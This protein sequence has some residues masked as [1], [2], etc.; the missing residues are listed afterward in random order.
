MS[1]PRVVPLTTKLLYL[2]GDGNEHAKDALVRA[3]IDDF[4]RSASELTEKTKAGRSKFGNLGDWA[5]ADPV[6]AKLIQRPNPQMLRLTELG[7]ELV[8]QKPDRIDR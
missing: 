5:Q 8:A 2:L 3:L 6:R 1:L 7:R 4:R